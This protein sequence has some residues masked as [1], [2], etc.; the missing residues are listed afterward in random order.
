MRTLPTHD[1]DPGCHEVEAAYL[2]MIAS[3]RRVIY[4]ES[5]YFASRR[6]GAAIARRLTEENGPEVVIVN[7][8]AAEGWLEP[9]VMDT[10]RARLVDALRRIDTH[11]RFRVYHPVTAAE[12]EIYVHSK[13]M[14]VDDTC[15]RVGSSNFNNR[16]MRVDTECDVIL[17]DGNAAERAR[18]TAL[19]DDLVA[20]HLGVPPDVVAAHLRRTGSLI[21]TIEALRGSGRSLVPYVL[22]DM[23]NIECWLADNEI[24]DPNGIDLLEPLNKRG[25]FKGWGKLRRKLRKRP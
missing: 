22:P 2:D 16:S 5:Q 12:A 20:E 23:S 6:I 21:Q 14:I 18:I 24:F 15:L 1:D 8:R 9:I 19:R 10:A 3:A 17:A 25:L 7:P 13:I 11:G 4:A